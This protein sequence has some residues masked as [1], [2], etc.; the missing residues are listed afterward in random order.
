MTMDTMHH[1]IVYV[2]VSHGDR[3]RE[4]LALSGAG[5]IGA[6]DSCSFTMRGTGRFRPLEGATP[7]IGTQ[8]VLEAVEEERI[9]VIIPK[10]TDLKALLTAVKAAHPYEEPAIHLLPMLDYKDSLKD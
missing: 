5:K 2:P 10:G 9:E 7:A 8:D 6:Y 1:L 3:V 4:A